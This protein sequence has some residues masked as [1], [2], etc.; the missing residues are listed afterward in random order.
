VAC[1]YWWA[2]QVDRLVRAGLLLDGAVLITGEVD[3]T[4]P[5]ET[6]FQGHQAMREGSWQ[7]DPLILD[8]QGLVVSLG[9]RGLVV[10]SGCGHA[11]IVNTVHYAQRPTGHDNVAAIVG[12]FHL[13]GPMFEPIIGPTVE[14]L[15]DLSP[16]LL[17]PA[18]CTGWKACLQMAARFPDAFVMSTVGS[19]INALRAVAGC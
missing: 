9:D 17:V 12:G 2:D 5:F 14:A 15:A 10:L 3:R 1:E 4:T 6:G 13:S 18:H 19:T 16:S 7:N 8:D 11:G